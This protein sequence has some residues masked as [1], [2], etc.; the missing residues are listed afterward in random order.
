MVGAFNLFR[1]A[2]RVGPRSL[3]IRE[4]RF[5][6]VLYFE[7]PAEHLYDLEADPGEQAPLA[8][9]LEKPARRRLLEAA[10]E[11][12]QRSYQQRDERLRTRARRHDIQLEWTRSCP[13]RSE[14]SAF[15]LIRV[16][17]DT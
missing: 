9:A 2:N 3:S 6:L 12:L 14:V 7:P 17:P 13:Q 16:E 5:K 11:H 4:Q 10:R 8:A 15:G 1:P